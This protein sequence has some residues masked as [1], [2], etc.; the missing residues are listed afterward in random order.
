MNKWLFMAVVSIGFLNWFT[1]GGITSAIVS[2]GDKTYDEEIA[3]TVSLH[4]ED[5]VLYATQWCG[6][7]KKTR[8]FLDQKSIAYV[9]YDIE[10]SDTGR[11]QYD[12]LNG[13]GVPLL[14]VKSNI[15]RGYSPQA[16][17]AALDK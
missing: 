1:D 11:Q 4:D 13:R 6:Y 17:V 14:V 10:T 3:E 15:I 2:V 9:E 12:R 5:V 8:E 16:I 7:C